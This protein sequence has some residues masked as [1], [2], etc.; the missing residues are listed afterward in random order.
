MTFK[1]ATLLFGVLFF[2]PMGIQA[3]GEPPLIHVFGPTWEQTLGECDEAVDWP[4]L[5]TYERTYTDMYYEAYLC[6]TNEERISAI[7]VSEETR[8]CS[9]EP[10]KAFLDLFWTCP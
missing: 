2:P 7:L 3:R 6:A 8:D 5:N 9:L 10:P 4:P 1:Q